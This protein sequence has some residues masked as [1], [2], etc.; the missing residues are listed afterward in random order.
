MKY[1]NMTL[2]KILLKSSSQW[3]IY[4][5]SKDKKKRGRVVGNAIGFSMLHLLLIGF[6][7]TTT[8]GYGRMGVIDAAP[9][10][11]ALVLSLLSFVFTLFKSNGYLFNFKEYDM[12]M[13]LPYEP[14][15]IAS[16]KFLY[17]Y[18]HS[19]PMY[20]E[21]SLSI[22]IVYGAYRHPAIIVYPIW[23][24]LSLF[25]PVIPMVIAAF[26]GFLVA[27]ISS[28]F[29]MK[30][31]IQTILL[32]VLV[33]AAFAL[34][35]LSQTMINQENVDILMDNIV[36]KTQT[37][38]DVYFP[39]GW[40]SNAIVRKSILDILLLLFVTVDVYVLFIMI[41]GASY[42]AL[43]SALQS[44]AR[45]KK[46][47]MTSMK[48]NSVYKAIVF[49]EYKR[50]TGSSIYMVNAGL[51]EILSI[52]FGIATLIFGFDDIVSVVTK[53]APINTSIL[54]PAIPLIVYFFIG[55]V[56]TTAISPSLEGK[57]YWIV[58]S[59]PIEKKALYQGKMLFN[60]CLTVPPALFAILC[61]CI[62]AHV[63]IASVILY[64]IL[65]VALCAFST[66]WGCVCGLKHM[67]LDWENEIEIV[68]Q[69]AAVTTYLLPNMFATMGL[70]VLVVFLGNIMNA[71]LIMVVLT[72]VVSAL[73][74][75]SYRKVLSLAAE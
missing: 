69:S 1:R 47:E 26:L 2:L 55:M 8:I 37:I 10:L 63:P 21:I 62:S 29:R 59:L 23:I 15:E 9:I 16:A 35:I 71:N 22:M 32:L 39:A 44:H 7:V 19:I 41:V 27:K 31:I 6:C 13:S 72:V 11:C 60:M 12:L 50:F 58:Q 40:F 70:I 75:L 18:C 28:G 49:K 51:G 45:V 25:V 65:G 34:Q 43:N 67:R 52:L 66:T 57:N 64:I 17:M 38:G 30:N 54:Y 61:I 68:K 3:N 36:E 14:K 48:R 73:T 33:I 42:R 56:A 24:L 46:Y 4:K 53:G 74:L 5:Y 20:T